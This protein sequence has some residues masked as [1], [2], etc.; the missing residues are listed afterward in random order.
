MIEAAPVAAP[1]R[2]FWTH[3]YFQVIVAIVLG[4]IIGEFW[5]GFGA[6]LKP[7]GDGFVKLVRMVIAPLIFLTIVTGIARY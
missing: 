1:S 6:S 2:P 4:I 3:L 7:L 5:P